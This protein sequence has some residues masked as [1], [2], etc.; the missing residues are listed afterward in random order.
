[1]AR[2]RVKQRPQVGVLGKDLTRRSRGRCE[3]CDSREDVRAWELAPF[4][5]EPE[6]SRALMACGRCR[7]WLDGEDV[8]PREAWFL[9]SA[10]WSQEPAVQLAAAR[11]LLQCD[12]PD[13]PWMRDALDAVDVDP[14]TG[15]FRVSAA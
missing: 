12:D 14:A 15:E 4:P 6:M 8:I 9:S 11:L 3:L 10:V 1:M 13:S 7:S 5:E 2:K